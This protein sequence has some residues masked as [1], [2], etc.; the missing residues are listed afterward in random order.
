MIQPDTSASRGSRCESGGRPSVGIFWRVPDGSGGQ[1][2]LT[3]ATPLTDAEA[4][5]DCLTHPRSH[6]DVWEGWRLLGVAKLKA[7]GIPAVILQHEYEDFPRGRIVLHQPDETFWV[8]A[9]R[10]LQTQLIVAQIR[11][12][13]GLDGTKNVVRS[14]AHYR[15]SAAP[16]G[17]ITRRGL[18]GTGVALGPQFWGYPQAIAPKIRKI[19]VLGEVQSPSN[20]PL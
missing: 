20:E 6:H 2:L 5:G 10:R 16:R 15:P 17:R 11:Q 1:C 19:A 12:A 18:L 13:F 8:Y 4:Y 14:D 7:L 3:D 9:D